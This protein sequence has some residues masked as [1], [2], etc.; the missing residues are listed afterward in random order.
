MAV[1][2]HCSPLWH[3]WPRNVEKDLDSS[4]RRGAAGAADPVPI[5]FR[6]D[7]IAVPGRA[8]ARLLAL[9][10]RHRIPLNLAVVPVWL[11]TPR[12]H[13]LQRMAEKEWGLFCW[14]Q[15]GWRHQNHETTGKKQEFGTGRPT[16]RIQRDIDHG[17]I[18]LQALMGGSFFP[19]FTPP[20][21]RCSRAALDH[22][23][24]TGFHAV[25]RSA[26]ARPPAM[27][28]VPDLAVNVDLH[29]RR[30]S[31]PTEGWQGLFTE[32]EAALVSGRCGIMIHHQRMND[33]AFR[34]LDL[35]LAAV[36]RFPAVQPVSFKD[37]VK[38]KTITKA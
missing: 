14:H 29:T 24:A 38:E 22:L 16:H 10:R 26:G 30:E 11:T 21:N 33:T 5:F 7:D 8:V 13:T 25:S 36:S 2:Y 9:F 15:H 35:L 20:W 37:L 32:F 27:G 31:L 3:R 28:A 23:A 6:A 18:R 19:V 4:L 12:W 34:F 17:R 1:S